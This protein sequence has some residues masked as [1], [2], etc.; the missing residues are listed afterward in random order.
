M[1]VGQAKDIEKKRDSPL[2]LQADEKDFSLGLKHRVKRTNIR[3][4]VQPQKGRGA[5]VRLAEQG[6]SKLTVGTAAFKDADH[7]GDDTKCIAKAFE[8]MSQLGRDYAEDRIREADLRAEKAKRM[9]EMVKP[10]PKAKSATRKRVAQVQPKQPEQQQ[11]QQQQQLQDSSTQSVPAGEVLK[12]PSAASGA[13]D[14]V[15][16]ADGA[17]SSSSSSDDSMLDK[18]TMWELAHAAGRR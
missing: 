2:Q 5:L 3:V 12:K 15:D 13:E 6:K 17:S 16:L 7:D 10:K 9:K 4:A 18:P 1:T 8:F 11:Q 14:D